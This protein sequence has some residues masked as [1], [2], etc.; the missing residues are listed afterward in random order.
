MREMGIGHVELD[1]AHSVS[2][3]AFVAAWSVRTIGVED[4]RVA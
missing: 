2:V 3:G 4:R 1:G